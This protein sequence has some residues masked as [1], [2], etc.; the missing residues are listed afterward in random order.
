MMI[1]CIYDG[2]S[3]FDPSIEVLSFLYTKPS[4]NKK[5]GDRVH[6]TV[7]VPKYSDKIQNSGTC[8]NCPLLGNGCYVNGY[9]SI[10]Y[11]KW[12][13][14]Y[15][16]GLIPFLDVKSSTGRNTLKQVSKGFKLRFNVTGDPLAIPYEINQALMD[17]YKSYIMYSHFVDTDDRYKDKCL[18]S[19]HSVN[20]E[21]KTARVLPLTVEDYKNDSKYVKSWMMD[22]EVICPAQTKGINCSQCMLCETR[23]KDI[24]FLAHGKGTNKIKNQFV[25]EF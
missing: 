16:G 4:S 9:M 7:T 23:K 11:F 3:M 5:L 14:N 10:P 22:S 12:I 6:Y 25:M 24:V 18:F 19:V 21:Y 8:A 13:R 17:S 1:Y 20:R 15:K 2:I